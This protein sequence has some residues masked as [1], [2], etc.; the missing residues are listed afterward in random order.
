M[1]DIR[2]KELLF[3]Q[4]LRNNSPGVGRLFNVNDPEIEALGI[5]QRYVTEMV[6]SLLEA[7][8]IRVYEHYL[9]SLVS[10]LRGEFTGAAPREIE[11]W[12]WE[13][14]RE[15]LEYRLRGIGN[16]YHLV[17]TY[18]GL[19]C[20]E[21]LR[22]AL[23]SDRILDSLGI[24]LDWRYFEPELRIALARGDSLPVSVIAL[25]LDGFKRINDEFGHDP[26]DEVLRSYM[27][28]VR[29]TTG[30]LGQ[31]FRR[32]GD[33]V[34]VILPG[35]DHARGMAIAETIRTG[36]QTMIVEFEQRQL[37]TVTTSIGVAC[38]PPDTRSL[39]LDRIADLRQKAAKDLG[40]NR[41][42]GQ[43]GGRGCPP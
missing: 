34:R 18:T 38:S 20:I 9:H 24:L 19:R 6:I 14:P 39:Q 4:L 13:N 17:I 31:A 30:T 37:S 32:G 42:V 35:F 36:I 2:I 22:E 10:R 3:L 28:V 27:R 11:S 41:V 15:G 29:D 40:K 16:L 8:A 26:G 23:Q 7:G 43:G 5:N 21:E 12:E 25:D 1:D 33:E